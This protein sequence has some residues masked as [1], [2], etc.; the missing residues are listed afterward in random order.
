MRQGVIETK[1]GRDG[2]ELSLKLL[3]FGNSRVPA[4]EGQ[5]DGKSIVYKSIAYKTKN[6]H[7]KTEYVHST[8]KF[9]KWRNQSIF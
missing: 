2:S 1:S 6:K 7:Y 9:S 5:S 3:E 8:N 4:R